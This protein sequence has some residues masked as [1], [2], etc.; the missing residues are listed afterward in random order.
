MSEPY[1]ILHK[2][3]GQPAFDIARRMPC[4]HPERKDHS[5]CPFE[6]QDGVWWL[7]PTSGARAYPYQWFEVIRLHFADNNK[8]ILPLDE[9]A[10][11][12]PEHW[13]DHYACND[14]PLK[15]TYEVK[16]KAVGLLQSL[17]LVTKIERRV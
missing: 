15:E 7:I 8:Q 13:P 5:D 6:C 2:V 12:L 4:P 14:R 11:L 1:L 17:G 10:Q 9:L 16:A 3:R